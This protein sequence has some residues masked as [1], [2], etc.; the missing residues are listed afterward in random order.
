MSYVSRSSFA[1]DQADEVRLHHLYPNACSCSSSTGYCSSHWVS[2]PT[3]WSLLM[4]METLN[5]YFRDA[6]TLLPVDF[7]NRFDS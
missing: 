3:S 4:G 5:S 7:E 6:L 1:N 2:P